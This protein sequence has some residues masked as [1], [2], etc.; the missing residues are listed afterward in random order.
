VRPATAVLHG[1][2]WPPSS[3]TQIQPL[4]I[5]PP[6]A[7]IAQVQQGE[8]W[9]GPAIEGLVNR[10]NHRAG[11]SQMNVAFVLWDLAMLS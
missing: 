5:R 1:R 4:A 8:S 11:F 6:Q 7:R 10:E 3:A 2:N 9:C